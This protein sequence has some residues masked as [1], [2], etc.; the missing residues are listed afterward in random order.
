MLVVLPGCALQ[1]GLNPVERPETM[2]VGRKVDHGVSPFIYLPKRT[3]WLGFVQY[4]KWKGE[5][6]FT[7]LLICPT[8]LPDE[9]ELKHCL[10][11]YGGVKIDGS[12]SIELQKTRYGMWDLVFEKAEQWAIRWHIISGGKPNIYN[13]GGQ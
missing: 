13:M 12:E 5:Q 8:G 7:S 3:T 4:T 1:Y 2:E 9:G 11:S 10:Q 6:E